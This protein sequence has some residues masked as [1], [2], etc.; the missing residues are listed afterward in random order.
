MDGARLSRFPHL[1]WL[2]LIENGNSG[3]PNDVTFVATHHMISLVLSGECEV[4]WTTRGHER[5][6]R[7]RT[8]SVCFH[9]AD[10]EEHRLY[11][12]TASGY[13][14]S[15]IMIP[16]HHLDGFFAEEGIEPLQEPRRILAPT[17]A[18]L[19]RCL[20]RLST[21]GT[22]SDGSS[23]GWED[24]AARRLVLRLAELSGAAPPDWNDDESTF[25]RQ[26]MR[27]I[28]EQIE[29][30]VS[31][32]PSLTDLASS[33]GLS[34][35]HFARKFRHSTGLSLHRYRNRRRLQAAMTLL[36]ADDKTIVTIAA[37]LGFSS[38]SHLTRFFS[39]MTGITPARYRQ[40][41]RPTDG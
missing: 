12:T 37:R 23:D 19:Q 4:R 34:P 1:S 8:G 38:Q 17:D 18:I 16:N 15:V 5:W 9:A 32:G 39:V 7:E 30:D 24:E 20:L 35:S 33:V 13:S 21:L 6:W 40:A 27:R 29:S 26:T 41:F 10:H 31:A 2:H 25:D 3:K 14:A 22:A 11:V 28:A 36:I